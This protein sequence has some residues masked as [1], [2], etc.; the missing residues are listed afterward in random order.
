MPS[1]TRP[2]IGVLAVERRLVGHTHEELRAAAVADRSVAA[3]RPPRRASRASRAELRLQDAEPARAVER[4]LRRI[5][6]QRIAALD[7]GERDHAMKRRPVVRALAR[8]LHE[9]A[10][11]IRREI[12]R[13]SMMNVPGDVSTTACLPLISAGVI[14]V[15]NGAAFVAGAGRGRTCADA[16]IAVE[17][18]KTRTSV[19]RGFRPG[20]CTGFTPW[21]GAIP[22]IID[23]SHR[24]WPHG[25][26]RH[27]KTLSINRLHS[28]SNL[29]IKVISF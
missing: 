7:D 19:A 8:E 6:R 23:F 27:R 21:Q 5:L 20:R 15:V 10:D 14:G 3:P 18:T 1:E 16:P 28:H 11:V 9:V 25:I 17:R 2:K 29:D 22:P 4:G 12:G 24:T 13:R 26:E